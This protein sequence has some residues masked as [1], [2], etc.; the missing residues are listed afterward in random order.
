MAKE[1]TTT[2]LCKHCKTEIQ[3]K[4]KVCPQC[5]KKQGMG[6]AKK[7]LIFF[8]VIVLLG[9]FGGSDS[10]SDSTDVNTATDQE[11]VQSADQ[12][13]NKEDDNSNLTM[14]QKNAFGPAKDYLSFAA[15]SYDGLIGQL[16]YEGYSTEDATFAADNCGAD[17]NEQS[18][19]CAKNYLDVSPFSYTGLIKQLEYEEF[20]TE[21]AEYGVTGAG[22]QNKITGK[23]EAN[24]THYEVGKKVRQT[25]KELGDTM[26]EDLPTPTKSIKQ[27]EKE[28]GKLIE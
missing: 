25:I 15:F 17:W 3:K 16:E 28:Q 18:L 8:L 11:V 1:K 14:G 23:E 26:S 4:A 7:L 22:Y 21:Q 9:M 10:E 20:T 5:Q 6:L 27:I 13:S 12:T 19:K 24:R 2:K